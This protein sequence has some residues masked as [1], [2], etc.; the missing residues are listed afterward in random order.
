MSR[1]NHD[2]ELNNFKQGRHMSEGYDWVP[3][4]DE[5]ARALLAYRGRQTALVTIL[6]DSG[7]RGLEDEDP[8]DS[9]IELTE[10]DPFTFLALLNKQSHPQRAKVLE[11][12]KPRLN[13]SADVPTG[14][15]GIPKA[16]PRQ[17][18]LFPYRFE[19]NV[20]DVSKLWDLYEAVLSGNRVGEDVFEAARAVKFA[21]KAKLTQ[22]IFRAAPRRFFP[23]DGQTV[24]YLAGL[25]LPS[26]FS[27]AK[28]FQD[29]C[30][31]VAKRVAKPLY[32]QSH[33]A[34]F[35]NQRKKPNAEAEY[36]QKVMEA[37]VKDTTVTEGGGGVS[38]P[39]VNKTGLSGGGYRRN[40]NVAASALKLANFK[41]E[42]DAE[43]KTFISNAKGRP[44]MEAHH[45]IPFGNQGGFKFSLDV[46][47]N[48]V[49][50]C[51]NC[52]RLLHHGNKGD[53]A[54]E[55]AA[56]FALRRAR[57]LEKELKIS[58]TEL[59]KLYRGDLLEED[60]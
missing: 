42:I 16:D 29:I 19:R 26:E 28:E 23:V 35:L 24:S 20:D 59:M 47:A 17:A 15:L 38:L 45:L 22:A 14:F 8:E 1:Q 57:L 43:H 12:V 18:W 48:I 11:R 44:Y 52:H 7:V 37:A 4:Y 6:K 49:A 3:F 25:R 27:S 33:D 39:K 46:T 30:A 36:Q 32:E 9:P 10:I 55:I 58:A 21:G 2:F 50:L 41:C 13:I 34:W 54:K 51:P 60:A 53:K 40:P 5:M 31:L 56:L